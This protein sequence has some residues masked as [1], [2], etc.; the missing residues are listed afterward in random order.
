MPENGCISGDM[1]I[2]ERIKFMRIV[3]IYLFFLSMGG[4]GFGGDQVLASTEEGEIEMIEVIEV[5][6][7]VS[8]DKTLFETIL[9]TAERRLLKISGPLIWLAM[10][11]A[12]ITR[13][14]RIKGKARQLSTI[15]KICGYT[16]FS[17]GTIHG[18]FGLFF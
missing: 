13:H 6:E 12:I 16:A 2:T 15:H 14:V 5:V 4:I 3:I 7:P 1:L 10:A 11:S 8:A 17:V 18:L 9:A